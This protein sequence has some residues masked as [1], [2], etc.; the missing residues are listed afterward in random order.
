M[1]FFEQRVSWPSPIFHFI[2]LQVFFLLLVS[3]HLINIK[4]LLKVYCDIDGK[5]PYPDIEM[6][7]VD[8]VLP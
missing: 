8:F 6:F 4:A 1:G 7:Y 5:L 3:V 2:F